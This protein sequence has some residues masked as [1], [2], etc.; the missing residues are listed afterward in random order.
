HLDAERVAEPHELV[1]ELSG[2]EPLGDGEHPGEIL[3]PVRARQV[4]V[5]EVAQREGRCTAVGDHGPH[6][7][8]VPLDAHA[9]AELV[10]GDALQRERLTEVAHVAAHARPRQAAHRGLVELG[11]QPGVVGLH[12]PHGL[13]AAQPG[14]VGDGGEHRAQHRLGHLGRMAPRERVQV[15][16]VH[17]ASPPAA[18]AG[19]WVPCAD[20]ASCRRTTAIRWSTVTRLASASSVSTTSTTTTGSPTSTNANGTSASTSRSARSA[21]PTCAVAPTP[22]ARARAYGTTLPSTR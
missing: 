14:D 5:A 11:P 12:A 16:D 17:D 22:S 1:E 6:V 4:P 9:G 8:V 7:L 10:R 3:R 15:G 20:G 21:M 18:A 13:A 19:S 2:L